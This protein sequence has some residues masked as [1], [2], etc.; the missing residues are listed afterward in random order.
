MD[1]SYWLECTRNAA[2]MG[3]GALTARTVQ[4]LREIWAAREPKRASGGF[5]A[6]S[7]FSIQMLV[8]LETFV[9]RIFV[10]DHPVD[11]AAVEQLSDILLSEGSGT[12]L[13]QVKKK[14]N[15]AGFASALREAYQIASHCS[16]QL[17]Q[18]LTFQVACQEGDPSLEPG[19]IA[20]KS[21]FPKGETYDPVLLAR[22]VA[23]FDANEPVRLV[24]D[25]LLALQRTMTLA[26]VQDAASTI[27]ECLGE[28]FGAFDGRSRA[29]VE[30]AVYNV[31]RIVR[32]AADRDKRIRSA[33]RLLTVMD[34]APLPPSNRERQRLVF[35]RRPRIV[36]LVHDQFRTRALFDRARQAVRQ[37][38]ASL[39]EKIG[40]DD[41]LL[42]VFWIKGRSG[43]G[44]SVLLLQLAAE[45]V[46]SG[47][48]PF[49]TEM[50]ELSE[51]R[52]WIDSSPPPSADPTRSDLM[53]GLVDDLHEKVSEVLLDAEIEGWALRGLPANAIMTCGPTTDLEAVQRSSARLCVTSFEVP[54]LTPKE[55]EEFRKWYEARTG[56]SPSGR[57]RSTSNRLLVDWLLTLASDEP[58]PEFARNLR[59][60]LRRLEIAEASMTIAAA[61]ALDLGAPV[62]LLNTAQQ[63]RNFKRLSESGQRHF[64]LRTEQDAQGVYLGH[65]ELAWPLFK[66]W[67]AADGNDL[68]F[69][70]G[71]ELGKVI[72]HLLKSRRQT[73][74][75]TVLGHILDTKLI[76]RRFGRTSDTAEIRAI[77]A[78]VADSAF[79]TVSS[80]LALME[81][82]PIMPLWLIM[83]KR[84]FLTTPASEDLRTSAAELLTE[85]QL[86]SGSGSDVACALATGKAGDQPA[87]V[88]RAYLVSKPATPE[89]SSV[90]AKAL[91]QGR[92]SG[93]ALEWLRSHESD[94]E[95][96][97]AFAFAATLPYN[98]D[99]VDSASNFIK[100]NSRLAVTSPVVLNLLRTVPGVL[101]PDVL[102]GWL[103]QSPDDYAVAQVLGDVL[104]G[105]PDPRYAEIALNRLERG[106]RPANLH[107][108]LKQLIKLDPASDRLQRFL[109]K[110]LVPGVA[111]VSQAHT[112]AELLKSRS[113]RDRWMERA[114]GA[115]RLAGQQERV[116]ILAQL[117]R[118]TD[119][120]AVFSRVLEMIGQRTP[121]AAGIFLLGG[122]A[123]RLKQMSQE[124]IAGLRERASGAGRIALVRAL[125]FKARPR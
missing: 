60:T 23:R 106:E 105:W 42:H 65:P 122:L 35:G 4:E 27:T 50:R 125:A 119:D 93:F 116:V 88:A 103:R 110:W 68:P 92:V 31:I 95:A 112:L 71:T 44:K 69:A 51:I 107:E 80:E 6:L 124:Q 37:W 114:I 78:A 22:V 11:V 1:T 57:N 87:Q 55:M 113:V 2:A 45:L 34:L 54:V 40:A 49:V 98:S 56:G 12:R 61:N 70:L 74:A 8:A 121:D 21:I 108:M 59:N 102:L 79:E 52:N 90:V 66:S 63:K 99:F 10:E 85:A 36:E 104:Q 94:P 120:P 111:S 32:S 72:V 97:A 46:T 28:I 38:L 39:P 33:G 41:G 30:K 81:S 53:I 115:A 18:T 5:W 14:L 17:L 100:R 62:S 73:Q 29:N 15:A 43:D 117:L 83:Q 64:E 19:S 109:D 48:L 67:A 96:A 20:A 13:I 84:G 82:A 118:V 16:P 77:Q 7:G 89:S 3:N 24:A 9:R 25:P 47:R 76:R 86:D 58:A 101:P 26:G 123:E 75:R 91:R